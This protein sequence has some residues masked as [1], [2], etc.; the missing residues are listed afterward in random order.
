[1][2]QIDC[3]VTNVEFFNLENSVIPDY[4]RAPQKPSS[5]PQKNDNENYTPYFLKNNTEI[6]KKSQKE[7]SHLIKNVDIVENNNFKRDEFLVGPN[8]I[9]RKPAKN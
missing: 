6:L 2:M 7:N 8:N 5:P 4:L 3:E 1:M 9:Y